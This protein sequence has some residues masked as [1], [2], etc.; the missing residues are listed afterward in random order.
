MGT[1]RAT[2]SIKGIVERPARTAEEFLDALRLSR[3]PWSDQP[4]QR[5][6]FR[7][8]ADATWGL[9]PS[10]LRGPV[11]LPWQGWVF[12]RLPQWGELRFVLEFLRAAD[13][14][15]LAIPHDS[16]ALRNDLDRIAL[17]LD[18]GKIVNPGLAHWP[19][20]ELLGV[21]ALAQH[22]GVPT[23]LLDWSQN[24]LVAA[25][26]AAIEPA[27]L[28][29]T[30][31]RA[32]A[33]VWALSPELPLPRLTPRL[34]GRVDRLMY[35]LAPYASN[36]NLAAQTGVFTLDRLG[37][38][39][40]GL[41]VVLPALVRAWLSR[42][43]A[44]IHKL[45]APV[46][47]GHPVFYKFTLP[48]SETPKLL[49]LLAL[50]GVHVGTMFPGHKGVADSLIERKLWDRWTTPRMMALHARPAPRKRKR[51][52]TSRSTRTS[53]VRPARRDPGP[54]AQPSC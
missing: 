17:G 42:Q 5:W 50:E 15:G 29:P 9:I 47:E 28:H 53:T 52:R 23:R 48:H 12:A 13:L 21:V 33:A 20:N 2:L 41:E 22:Y 39:S 6:W 14:A 35:V 44:R 27:R 16:P 31:Q 34:G 7:G 24:P 3:L 43:T 54:A 40:V 46:W 51:T 45:L 30:R 25:Y 26:F 10:A 36:P 19:P 49:R 18:R 11:T 8:Q 32:R 4:L 1:R 38:P 37:S